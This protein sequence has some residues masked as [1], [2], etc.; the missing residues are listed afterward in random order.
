MGQRSRQLQ[1]EELEPRTVLSTAPLAFPSAAAALAAPTPGH[2]APAL[3]GAVHGKFAARPVTAGADAA[4]ALTGSGTV[5]G[6]GRVSLSGSV[7]AAGVL[8]GGAGGR[9]T[10]TGA[11]GTLTLRLEGTSSAGTAPLPG[12]FVFRVLRGS[13]AYR[14]LTGEGTINLHLGSAAQ[15]ALTIQPEA[16]PSSPP[17]TTPPITIA[18]GIAGVV[19]E[20]PIL[21]VQRPG[22]P[23]ARPVPGAIISVQPAGGG[24]EIMRQTADAMGNFQIA[25]PP[26]AYRIV[27]LPPDPSQYFPRGIPQDVAVAPNQVLTLTLEMDTGIR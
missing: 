1:V 4:Y 18:T 20:G 17:Q 5:A 15:F 27:P 26:G 11:R 12:Q 8:S 7:R 9:L 25:L 21:P 23:N 19:M 10:L 6:L 13:G 16:V 3:T 22:D 2:H 14:H 24:P